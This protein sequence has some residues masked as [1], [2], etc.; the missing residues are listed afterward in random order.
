MRTLTESNSNP[1]R[2]LLCSLFFE[3]CKDSWAQLGWQECIL[4]V[5]NVLHLARQHLCPASLAVKPSDDMDQ[6]PVF[7]CEK[8]TDLQYPWPPLPNWN[9]VGVTL[10]RTPPP[11]PSGSHRCQRNTCSTLHASKVTTMCWPRRNS[12][13]ALPQPP[14][15]PWRYVVNAAVVVCF[16]LMLHLQYIVCGYA[17]ECILI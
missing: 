9:C 11:T 17:T 1:N 7:L 12:L 13:F 15:S 16:T 10:L 8:L 2:S 3:V 5:W 6:I 4:N 14:I